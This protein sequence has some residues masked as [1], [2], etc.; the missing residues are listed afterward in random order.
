M[1]DALLDDLPEFEKTESEIITKE[2]RFS[3]ITPMFGGDSD[4]WE[5][6]LEAPVRAQSIKGQLRFW[7]RTMQNETD[8]VKLLELENA[9]WGGKSG[10]DKDGNYVRRK[11]RV[12][13]AVVKQIVESVDKAKLNAK[14]SALVQGAIPTYLSFP[15][16][17]TVKKEKEVH[18]ITG[19]K[20]TLCVSFPEKYKDVVL[21]TLK[22]WTL[23]G[24]VGARTRRGCGSIYCR[25][26]LGEFLSS[27]DIKKFI[28]Q[29]DGTG[30]IAG[31][32][33]QIVDSIIACSES[34]G[35]GAA[36]SWDRLIAK[37]S[38]FRQSRNSYRSRSHW[39]EPDAIRRVMD[40]W[41]NDHEPKHE[42][43]VWFP[44]AAFGLPIITKFNQKGRGK[45][46]PYEAQLLPCNGNRWPSPVIIK[47]IKLSSCILNVVLVLNQQF[48]DRLE[49][50]CTKEEGGSSET[51]EVPVTAHP[52]NHSGKMMRQYNN[53]NGKTVYEGLF[54][55][56]GV[57]VI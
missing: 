51:M 53:L 36:E 9:L 28:S 43:G 45:G 46:D 21:N 4:S 40:F 14:R 19:A 15:V 47:A 48:P 34:F 25:E 3:L 57:T 33:C 50:Y 23:F 52:E 7:W 13:I 41:S 22:L 11:S 16:L 54:E 20:F 32:Y 30:P 27:A 37:Y 24:G 1:R 39:P 49:L 31:S 6:N 5:L 55:A 42:D 2:Y 44:R 56:L 17:D 38:Q 12:Q 29:W 18:Y 10:K 35:D 8:P 26:L